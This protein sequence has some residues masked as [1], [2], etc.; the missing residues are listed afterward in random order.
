M[1]GA[2]TILLRRAVALSFSKA[3]SL[4]VTESEASCGDQRD[5]KA[6]RTNEHAGFHD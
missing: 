2:L 3:S 4:R 5:A 6:L 1:G